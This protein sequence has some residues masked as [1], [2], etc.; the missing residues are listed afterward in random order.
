MDPFLF[1]LILGFAGLVVMAASGLASHGGDHG[2]HGHGS[3]EVGGHG[4]K[5]LGGGHGKDI[6]HH[7]HVKDLGSAH[8]KDIVHGQVKDVGGTPGNDL[9]H[10][11]GKDLTHGT[12]GAA[13]ADGVGNHIAH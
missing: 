7:V 13:G 2:G 9:G 3:K 4:G 11:H 1:C 5:E 12:D 10:G 6:G 8:V